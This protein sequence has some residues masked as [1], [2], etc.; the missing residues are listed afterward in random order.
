MDKFADSTYDPRST[1]ET[2]GSSTGGASGD[3]TGTGGT[4]AEYSAQH[5]AGVNEG[6]LKPKG[7][8]IQEVGTFEDEERAPNASFQFQDIESKDDPGR[9]ATRAFENANAKV[10]ADAG[11]PLAGKEGF[12]GGQGGYENLDSERQA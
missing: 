12:Q 9:Y 5:P 4:S 2:S 3:A 7:R 11:R 8:N 10:A 1:G 6:N